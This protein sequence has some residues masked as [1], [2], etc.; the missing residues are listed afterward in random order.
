MRL[1]ICSTSPSASLLSA[2]TWR[3]SWVRFSQRSN[4]LFHHCNALP[5][6]GKNGDLMGEVESIEEKLWKVQIWFELFKVFQLMSNQ[7]W[8]N[9]KVFQL[10]SNFNLNYPKSSNQCE[11]ASLLIFAFAFS[12]QRWRVWSVSR[13]WKSPGGN[14]STFSFL[15]LLRFLFTCSGAC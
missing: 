1:Q 7:I 2:A 3:Q 5:G 15:C 6:V 8:I 14:V 10:M 13:S 9:V 4:V 11:M 12:H